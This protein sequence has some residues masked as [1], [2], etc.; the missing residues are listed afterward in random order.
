VASLGGLGQVRA[1]NTCSAMELTDRAWL[2]VQKAQEEARALGDKYVGSDHLLLAM[3][4][5]GDGA[6]AYVLDDLGV[7]YDTVFERLVAST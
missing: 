1:G 6:G 2:I 5:D 7:S 3:L 4:R